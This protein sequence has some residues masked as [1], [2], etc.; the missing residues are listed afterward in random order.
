M[1]PFLVWNLSFYCLL[2]FFSIID[3]IPFQKRGLLI[4]NSAR[5]C[6]FYY[7]NLALHWNFHLK[8]NEQRFL[9]IF[10]SSEIGI[11]TLYSL[12]WLKSYLK[13]V[14]ENDLLAC[15]FQALR[16]MSTN[17]ALRPNQYKA[18]CFEK[19]LFQ[20]IRAGKRTTCWR[21]E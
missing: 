11:L 13:Q 17:A 15:R 6:G 12:P 8:Q 9:E 1:H 20:R 7:V 16:I 4:L 21:K 10:S 2:Q 14:F 3:K 18:V 5:A 19:D